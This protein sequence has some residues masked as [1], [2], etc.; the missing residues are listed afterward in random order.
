MLSEKN[1]LDAQANF[2]V[3]FDNGLIKKID[4]SDK[5]IVDIYLRNAKE[6]IDLAEL[7]YNQNISMMWV[8]VCSY[9]SMFY[10][11]NSLLYVNG[12][13]VGDKIA[14]K[15]TSDSLIYLMRN[16]LKNYYLEIYIQIEDEAEEFAQIKTDSLLEN[17]NLERRKRST[18]QYETPE[19]IKNIKAETSLKRAKEFLFEIRHLI[20]KD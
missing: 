18:Y 5:N 11:A 19:N 9:Y 17:L 15:V 10:I 4:K 20:K 7:A 2:N 6:S 16:K 13:K 14:H 3:Y 1:I 8:I 12:Y